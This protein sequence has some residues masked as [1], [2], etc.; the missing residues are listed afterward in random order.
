MSSHLRGGRLLIVA[1]PASCCSSIGWVHI[2][3]RESASW[4]VS[5]AIDAQSGQGLLSGVPIGVVYL[6]GGVILGLAVAW[7]GVWMM[8]A[9]DRVTHAVEAGSAA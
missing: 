2:R 7:V 9:T 8:R 3:R 4:R 1:S 5:D 6:T